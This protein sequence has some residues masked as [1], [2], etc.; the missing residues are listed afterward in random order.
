MNDKD[1]AERFSIGPD[2]RGAP[3]PAKPMSA[4]GWSHAVL[5]LAILLVALGLRLN[6]L[7]SESLWID[8]AISYARASY[9]P[10]KLVRDSLR[11]KHVPTYFLLLHYLM[12]ALGDS[13]AALRLPSAVFGAGAAAVTYGIGALLSGPIA[14]LAAGLLVA[15]APSQ[16]HY[17]Q[18]ARMYAMVTFFTAIGV[19]AIALLLS[20][21]ESRNALPFGP[22]LRQPK[23][24]T[25]SMA[26]VLLLVGTVAPLY[27][28]NTAV[29]YVIGL[30]G[31]GICLW[32]LSRGARLRF[33][34]NWVLCQGL[35]LL[36]WSPWIPHLL[37]QSDTFDRWKQSPFTW[38]LA[39]D[40]LAP[41][42]LLDLEGLLPWLVAAAIMLAVVAPGR[43]RAH[44][45]VLAAWPLFAL[46]ACAVVSFYKANMTFVRTLL[47]I[48]VPAFA[49]AGVGIARLPHRLG[50]LTL[51]GLVFLIVPHVQ[52]YYR[53]DTKPPWRE[54]IQLLVDRTNQSSVIVGT[55][56]NRF[57]HYYQQRRD[58]P[59]SAR[60]VTH[61][62]RQKRIEDVVGDA[63][64]FWW[65]ASTY[66]TKTKRFRKMVRKSRRYKRVFRRRRGAAV[67]SQYARKAHPARRPRARPTPD[68]S[69]R[70]GATQSS[71]RP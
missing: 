51:L 59:L 9:E 24:R 14:G 52:E 39:A 50:L 6:D 58:A 19:L 3:V 70:P 35:A 10:D 61:F 71:D 48:A 65:L 21:P 56:A 29:F 25:A 18:E 22:R 23:E 55:G 63:E 1:V 57:V 54:Y 67:L 47:W 62:N 42:M 40:Q 31:A 46:V 17:G 15:L 68:G 16:I 32:L 8:E 38:K 36:L 37:A 20:V 44:T 4:Q 69:A 66:S 26:W 45:W 34:R 64:R 49:I 12:P 13:E 30:Q 28:H 33:A 60:T 11:R 27:L 41:I 53:A 43:A 2:V 7:G 5:A